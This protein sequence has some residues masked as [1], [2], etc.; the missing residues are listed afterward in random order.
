MLLMLYF[1]ASFKTVS[2][3]LAGIQT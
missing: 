3:R 2:A 1:A